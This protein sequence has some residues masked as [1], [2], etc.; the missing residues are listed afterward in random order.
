MNSK[1]FFGLRP[2]LPPFS[3]NPA[4]ATARK[5]LKI[6][7]EELSQAHAEFATSLARESNLQR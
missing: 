5:E 4:N 3:E 7:L 6:I 1:N 2:S